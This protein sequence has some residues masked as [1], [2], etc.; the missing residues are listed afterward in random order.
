LLSPWL[1]VDP[2]WVKLQLR[3][4]QQRASEWQEWGRSANDPRDWLRRKAY[5]LKRALIRN[6]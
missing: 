1:P 6:L 3:I 2:L 5:K 4:S